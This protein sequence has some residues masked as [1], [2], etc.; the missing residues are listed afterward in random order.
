MRPSARRPT[1]IKLS[2][3]KPSLL[4]TLAVVAGL[5]TLSVRAHA[6]GVLDAIDQAHRAGQIDDAER[7]LY[8]VAAVRQ[9][10][11][12]PAAWQQLAREQGLGV[13]CATPVLVEAAQ[14]MPRLDPATRSKLRDLFQPPSDLAYMVEAQTPYPV[15]VSYD[16]PADQS[17]AQQ[18]LDAAELSFQ[19]EVTEFGYWA[20]PIEPNIGPYRMF[21]GDMEPGVAAYTVPYA[22]NDA[23]AWADAFSY[24]VVGR[25]VQGDELNTTVAHEF[26]HACQAAMDAAEV[27]SFWENTA[28][29]VMTEVYPM[30]FLYTTAFF[31]DFQGQPWRPLEYFSSTDAY[32]YGG[33]LWTLF[34]TRTYGNDDPTW[35]RQVWE[36]SV[37]NGYD[38]EPDYFDSIDALTAAQGGIVA[39]TMAFSEARWFVGANDDGHHLA[40]AGQWWGAE[41]LPSASWT[42]ASLPLLD[43]GPDSADTRPEPNGCNYV[44]LN[45]NTAAPDAIKFSFAGQANIPWDVRLFRT[46]GQAGTV[47]TT[48]DVDAQ[49]AGELSET[50]DDADGFVLMICQRPDASYDPD[51]QAWTQGDYRYSIQYDLPPPTVTAVEPAEVERGA[52]GLELVIRGTGFVDDAGVKLGASGTRVALSLTAYI[53]PTELRASVVVAPDADLGPRDV[54]VTNP[55]GDV[56]TGAGL[57]TI[58]EPSA[59][60]PAGSTSSD[61]GCGCRVARPRSSASSWALGFGLGALVGLGARR[62]SR[63]RRRR[64][65]GR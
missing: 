41:P 60:A 36:G 8:R 12:L 32:Q 20:P 53:S 62:S 23:T 25:Q 57:L 64:S 45:V 33:A 30:D 11:L 65:T 10:S 43:D 55:N 14:A 38:N 26:N 39:A 54:S 16:D 48:L 3:V 35:L 27:V 15:R 4:F 40:G 61:T 29:F 50:A 44:Q 56:G 5:C 19:K 42:T 9:P 28:E 51:A 17:R 6:A 37:Q 7:L 22:E 46:G 31:P 52:H 13:R 21:I 63:A 34:L 58:V 1:R 47:S 49:G 59:V 2:L 24:I 18:I